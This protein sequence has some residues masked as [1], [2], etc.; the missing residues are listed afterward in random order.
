MGHIH[1]TAAVDS[2]VEL[3][4]DVAVGPHCVIRG[5]VSIADGTELV[6][7]VYVDGPATI[8]RGNVLF[9]NVC[10][11]FPPQDRKFPRGTRGPGVLIGDEN[12][13]REGTTVNGSTMDRPTTLGNRN[14]LMA[15]SHVGHDCIV[16]S[17]ITLANGALLGGHVQI[18]DSTFLGGN[19]AVHQ[20]CRIGRLVMVGGGAIVTQDM[21][22]FCVA[23]FTKS[24]DMLNLVGL[25]RAG[26]GTHI[27]A[28]KRAFEIMYLSRLSRPTA[29]R[30]IVE[31]L[32]EDALCI[33]FAEFCR[34][35]T[36]GLTPY[37]GHLLEK[38][39]R[40]AEAGLGP[41]A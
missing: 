19:S 32:A 11:G 31:E 5:T 38:L 41:G 22:P 4:S 34:S 37:G 15:N 26:L 36:R 30:R 33:E 10:I 27:P 20:F 40:A 12:V 7:N 6:H 18:G 23:R 21:P 8:G 29:I 3:A 28:L 16:G 2:S 1:P 39:Q 25:R 9:P 14:F 17:D 24:L 35:S 13:F